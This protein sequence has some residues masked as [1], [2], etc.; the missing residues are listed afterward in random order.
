[1]RCDMTSS[2]P[3]AGPP[4][5]SHGTQTGS[6]TRSF[7]R[8]TGGVVQPGATAALGLHVDRLVGAVDVCHEVCWEE[9]RTTHVL[10]CGR[11]GW[12]AGGYVARSAGGGGALLT[13]CLWKSAT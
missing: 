2:A 13:F 5:S 9:Q 8:S 3:C 7:V 6:E 1:M 11:K 12:S 4:W 10:D